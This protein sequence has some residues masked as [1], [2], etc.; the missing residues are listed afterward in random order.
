MKYTRYDLKKRSG[1]SKHFEV[2]VIIVLICALVIGTLLSKALN[3]YIGNYFDNNQK[4]INGNSIQLENSTSYI[5]IQCGI[6]NKKENAEQLIVNLNKIGKATEVQDE[7]KIRV[8][9]GI[10]NKEDKVKA[11]MKLLSDNKLQVHEIKYNLKKYN[12]C[13]AQIIDVVNADIAVFSKLE[14]NNVKAIGTKEFKAWVNNL[15]KLDKTYK[16]STILSDFKVY[17]NKLPDQL[18]KDNLN[19]NSSFL[20]SELR[21]YKNEP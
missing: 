3:K 17:V 12:N 9:F 4:T 6:F 20:Y 2:L 8:I 14:D 16:N 19:S 21:K 7:N 11:A 5:F 10:Y 13:D 15:K 1:T 18:T